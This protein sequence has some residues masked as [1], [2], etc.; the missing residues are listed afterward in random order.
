[1][2]VQQS[3]VFSDGQELVVDTTKQPFSAIG[4]IRLQGV[5]DS[6]I[7]FCTGALISKVRWRFAVSRQSELS[8]SP[9]WLP[10]RTLQWY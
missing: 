4:Q 2:Q 9:C 1:M 5:N 7:G 3:G 10:C 6:G 8:C